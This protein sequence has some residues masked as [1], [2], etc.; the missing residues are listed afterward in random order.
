VCGDGIVQPGEQCDDG[1]KN[2]KPGWR[3]G[4]DCQWTPGP[5]CGNGVTEWPEECDDGD[6]NGTDAS[7]CTKD[8]KLK[9]PCGQPHPPVCGNGV[10]EYPDEE[11]DEGHLNGQPGSHC[12][13]DCKK[14]ECPHNGCNNPRCGD[15][16]VDAG[17]E[18]DE[19][20]ANN[21]KDWSACDAHCKKKHTEVGKQCETCNPNPFFNKCTITTSCIVAPGNKNYCACRAGYR[22]NGLL[23]TDQRQF[24]LKFPGQEYRVFVAPGIECDTLCTNPHPGPDSCQEV[25]V[26]ADC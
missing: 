15:G 5:V 24:R 21:G 23:P 18:C 8:C 25:P 9:E 14:K 26:R 11:C 12:T 4:K 20:D 3:C 16:K 19:E 6:L 17:E 22:A 2:G 1:E 13:T 7:H 10:V